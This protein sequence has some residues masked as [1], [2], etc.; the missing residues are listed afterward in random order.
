MTGAWERPSVF[1]AIDVLNRVHRADPTVLPKLIAER[2][3]CNDELAKDPTVQVGETSDHEYEVGFLGILNGI[4][5]VD[6]NGQ[7]FIAAR[8]D[9]DDQLVEFVFNEKAVP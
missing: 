8:Y 2:V 3:R 5:G 6:S 1:E 9:D 4:H 7:G